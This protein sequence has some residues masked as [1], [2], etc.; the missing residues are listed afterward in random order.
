MSN[1]FNNVI[2]VA[3]S[4]TIAAFVNVII[5]IVITRQLGPEGRGI[6]AS[7][8]VVPA[9]VL[10]FTELGMRRSIMYHVG[11]KT[12]PENE[13]I[14]SLYITVLLST[15][16]GIFVSL[17]LFW[18]QNNPDFTIP[19]I[20]IAISMVPLQL[21]RRYIG[22]YF[23]GK[24]KYNTS[25]L[26]R[27]IF[28]V[29]YLIMTILLM[30]I[31][32]MGLL[33]ALLS[34]ILSNII[35]SLYGIHLVYRSVSPKFLLKSRVLKSILSFG[36]MYSAATFV[37]MLHTKIDILILGKLST[38]E[39]IG[40]YS[41]AVAIAT[42]WQIP[43]EVGGV[44]I[45]SSANTEEP[46]IKNENI[47]RLIRVSLILGVVSYIIL[48]AF[49]PFLVRVLYGREFI[50]SVGMIRALLPGI[51]LLIISN[52]MASRL[53]GDGKP[54][55]FMF[56]AIPGL[57]LNIVLNLIWIPE[58]EALGA[59]YATVVSYTYQAVAGTIVYSKM[60]RMPMHKIF[61]F[62]KHDFSFVKS[63][64]KSILERIARIK[65]QILKSG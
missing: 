54:F 9:M 33:G 49:A 30:W 34:V 45:S 52:I 3:G 12:Y 17:F 62:S 40:F 7:I 14:G 65:R 64:K 32:K 8:M 48:F 25:I 44:I 36:V 15:I 19:L 23:M 53:A 59:A 50:E 27:W 37:M 43:F 26:I 1:F 22:G 24:Q 38:M 55:I 56:I 42:N 63:L 20:V 57:I 10:K 6:Y 16:L 5:G 28:L 21:I 29:L 18:F 4:N 31:L 46:E 60:V 41:L 11:K 51:L 2:K 39:Q 13:I 58:Y 47:A 35:A 61:S